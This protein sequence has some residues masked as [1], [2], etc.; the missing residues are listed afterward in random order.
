MSPNGLNQFLQSGAFIAL[1]DG[2]MWL[3]YGAEE[4]ANSSINTICYT[5]FFGPSI[6]A[7]KF[8]Q[9]IRVSRQELVSLLTKNFKLEAFLP[10]WQAPSRALFEQ[11]FRE[12]MGRILRGE[13]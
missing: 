13:I 12:I 4:G 10:S 8:S 5:D 7:R 6:S 1:P 11:S 3:F 9:K 2:E